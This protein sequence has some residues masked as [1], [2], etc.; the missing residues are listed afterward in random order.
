M[1]LLSGWY[2]SLYTRAGVPS[3]VFCLL[4][5]KGSSLC[6]PPFLYRFAF[7]GGPVL[8]HPHTEFL[9]S[10]AWSSKCLDT[11]PLS[12]LTALLGVTAWPYLESCALGSGGISSFTASQV[13]KADFAH[14]KWQMHQMQSPAASP[15]RG[16]LFL[17]GESHEALEELW[18]HPFPGVFPSLILP[19]SFFTPIHSFFNVLSQQGTTPPLQKLRTSPTALP[20]WAGHA[21]QHHRR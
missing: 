4:K 16:I 15:L 8:L 2:L 6:S 14:L 18:P 3:L 11:G 17:W 1:S 21:I 5:T 7:D 20:P 9:S 13:H 12:G 10:P 19:V